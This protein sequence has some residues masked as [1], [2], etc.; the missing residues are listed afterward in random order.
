MSPWA[1][2]GYTLSHITDMCASQSFTGLLRACQRLKTSLGFVSS[3]GKRIGVE[4][5]SQSVKPGEL[6]VVIHQATK[7]GVLPKKVFRPHIGP[8][9][10]GSVRRWYLFFPNSGIQKRTPPVD[11]VFGRKWNRGCQIKSQLFFLK[12][13]RRKVRVSRNTSPIASLKRSKPVQHVRRPR[14]NG[15]RPHL[16]R[17]GLLRKSA[18]WFVS[19]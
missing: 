12:V 15:P 16:A 18:S 11:Q 13:R 10:S 9:L 2:E 7:D 6:R 14:A 5:V 8:P 1:L 19:S 3:T 17:A 4:T